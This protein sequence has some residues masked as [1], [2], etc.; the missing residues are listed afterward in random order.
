MCSYYDSCRM[1]H[2]IILMGANGNIPFSFFICI[3]LFLL[4]KM[5]QATIVVYDSF[6]KRARNLN[7]AMKITVYCCIIFSLVASLCFL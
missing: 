1:S 4:Q 6:V 2:F 3:A 7:A 5:L